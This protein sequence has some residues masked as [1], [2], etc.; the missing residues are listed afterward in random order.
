MSIFLNIKKSIFLLTQN[1]FKKNIIM[2]VLFSF[3]MASLEYLSIGIFI[4]ILKFILVDFDV[5]FGI[6]DLN[7]SKINKNEVIFFSFALIFLIF[8][9]RFLFSIFF[10]N[11]KNKI[12]YNINLKFSRK[13][14]SKYLYEDYS[15]HLKKNSSEL[16]TMMNEVLGFSTGAIYYLSSLFIDLVITFF[17]IVLL[18][19]FEFIGTISM[20]LLFSLFFFI[21]YFYYN[22]K[23]REIGKN[24]VIYNNKRLKFLQESFSGIKELI[25]YNVRKVFEERLDKIH[26]F[27]FSLSL[28]ERKIEFLPRI[29]LEF[30]T[31]IFFIILTLI[32][33]LIGK[34]NESILVTI[35]IF[36]MAGFK[37]MPCVSRILNSTQNLRSRIFAVN[38]IYD[39]LIF[40]NENDFFN[41]VDNDKQSIEKLKFNDS[42]FFKNITFRYN[43]ES[44]YIFENLSLKILKGSSVGIYG[45]SGSGKSSFVD[46][47]SGF[48]YAE[49]GSILIDNQPLN[50]YNRLNWYKNIAYVPQNYQILDD[51][52]YNNIIFG[53][54]LINDEKIVNKKIKDILDQL[55]LT[56]VVENLPL[57]VHTRIGEG[58]ISLSGGQR[59]RVVLARA[60]FKESDVIILDESTNALDSITEKEIIDSI[61]SIQNKTVIIISHKLNSIKNCRNL[62]MFENQKINQIR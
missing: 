53:N 56:E 38:K 51:S 3:I 50:N 36:A 10:I 23:I 34:E 52:I 13:L 20:L 12:I 40:Q 54:S 59:Q 25:I 58:G 61:L 29:F 4:P 42:I 1:G 2:F 19:Q 16:I 48:S 41:G 35:S 28:K 5:S 7:I 8:F 37:L 49:S 44:K 33:Y 62:L 57:K 45:K 39:E 9:I 24:R 27:F 60:L 55:D 46:L 15:F 30:I 32:L 47:L 6:F 22:K 18:F 11:Y 26:S 43:K 14:F 31:L 17:I 21:Y